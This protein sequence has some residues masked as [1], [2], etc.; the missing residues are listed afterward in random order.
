MTLSLPELA[1][2]ILIGPSGSGKSTFAR[3]HFLPTQVVSSDHCRAMVSDQEND[4]TVTV[5]AFALLHMIVRQRL[6]LGRLTVVDATNVQP[7]ARAPLIALAREF[8]TLAIAIVL[9]VPESVCQARNRERPDRNFSPH[10]V[11]NQNLNMLRSLKRLKR[12]GFHHI[13]TLDQIDTIDSVTIDYK[14]LWTNRTQL[15]GP[16]D[17]IG[18]VHGCAD[19][20]R[21]LLGQ[22]GYLA[23]PVTDLPT[24][25][26]CIVGSDTV[27]RHPHGRR[28]IFVG[29]LVDR[30]PKSLEVVMIVYQMVRAESALAVAGNHDAR[31]VKYF[32]K[33]T[34]Q[35]THGLAETVDELQALPPET[36]AVCVKVYTEFLDSLVSHYLLDRGQLAVAHAGVR[37]EMQGRAS[38]AV[39]EFALYG[40]VT[41][42]QDDQGRPVRLKWARDYRGQALVVY[43]HTP[44]REPEWLNHTVNI[45]TGCVY[46]GALTAFRY[47]EQECISTPA[48]RGYCETDAPFGLPGAGAPLSVQQIYDTVLDIEDVE[49]KRII[50]TALRGRI[51]VRRE[52]A[53]AALEVMSRFAVD[54]KWLIYLPPTM[55]PSETTTQP[56]LLEH[57]R[58]AF[59]YYQSMG[60]D[61]VLCEEKHMGS[62]AVVIVC[63]SEAVAAA[64]FGVTTGE[65]GMVTT[66]TGRRFFNDSQLE[67]EFLNRLT[68]AVGQ[69]RLWESLNTDWLCLDCELMP[70][71]AK[72][73]ELLKTQYAAVGAAGRQ[74]LARV[75][76]TLQLAGARLSDAEQMRLR[77]L[78]QK[79]E[80]SQQNIHLFTEAYSRYCWPVES[81]TDYKLAPFHIMASEG[82]VHTDQ[83]HR[84]HME[85]ISQLCEADPALLRTTR[86]Q[87]VT[88]NDPESV[89]GG[90]AW[91]ES[92]TAAGG[93]GMVVK[94]RDFLQTGPRGIVQ[95]AIKCR[96]ADYL[97]IIYGPDYQLEANLTRLRK[98]GLGRKR[99]LALA[100]FALG[101]EGLTRFVAREPLRRVHECVFAV[102]AYESEPVDP[103]L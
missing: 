3:K 18:D 43:G 101:I 68:G 70:W 35:L 89:A 103:R 22:L 21:I 45:D 66:R 64:R 33:K 77:E 46:G 20:L 2:V 36:R 50:Q 27:Y 17:I 67:T 11:R 95:P 60:T 9:K 61:E 28:A 74:A 19:E 16:F 55:S 79:Y 12:E 83:P 29:D 31:L 65:A 75:V 40:E 87:T 24:E 32:F 82:K 34:T 98:R 92:L 42:E 54:P 102:L 100:E 85:I 72:A 23:H 37:A 91:W 62:R 13:T 51:T 7:E 1:L 88:L 80:T 94:P 14:P 47:P 96:G 48:L 6:A 5:S 90:V 56:G 59:A 30:G 8:H 63:Q 69:A 10:V 97:R 76:P 81:V 58:E 4:Q 71:S 99:G 53:V 26:S 15:P 49:G 86:T 78:T 84:W 93:E 52:N 41:G 25:L 39:R 44:V 73:Q 57:P 38:R